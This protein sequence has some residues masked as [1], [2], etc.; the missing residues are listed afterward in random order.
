MR[1]RRRHIVNMSLI[2]LG[3]SSLPSIAK[4]D[5]FYSIFDLGVAAGGDFSR[6]YSINASGQVAGFS[7]ASGGAFTAFRTTATGKF[8]DSGADL[9]TLPGRPIASA[10]SINA[11]GQVTG[12]SGHAFRTSG[13]GTLNTAADLGVL[14]GGTSS[15]GFGINASGQVVGQSVVSGNLHAFR[16]SGTGNLSDPNADLGI[17]GTGNYSKGFG[18]NDSGQITGV[19]SISPG[20]VNHAFR[21]TA[22]GNL[23]TAVDLG[24]FPGAVTSQGNAINAGGQ[25]VGTSGTFGFRTT[26][27]GTLA[28]ATQI[29]NFPGGFGVTE[30]KSI[31]T[32]GDVVGT[33]RSAS[34]FY[35]AFLYTD[36][37]GLQDLN[38][39]I[40]TGDQASWLLGDALGINDS[41]Q[42]TGIGTIGGQDHGYRLTLSASGG[43][44]A[45]AA[46]PEAGTCALLGSLGLVGATVVRR[47][48]K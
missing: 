2:T 39:L 21:T 31:N 4:A 24:L 43:P 19:A 5:L 6:G 37:G 12:T 10:R 3:L 36:A 35:H 23:S 20:G 14:S 42:V 40:S 9:G 13:T 18:I 7:G 1:F 15:D 45:G 22:T 11:T 16:T 34:G 46:T 27:T 30:A 28:T 47:R 8:S 38:S 48:N 17:L 44:V 33:A 26:A 32:V 25:V 29:G 41:G